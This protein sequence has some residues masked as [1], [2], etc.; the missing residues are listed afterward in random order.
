MSQNLGLDLCPHESVK[1]LYQD[2]WMKYNGSQKESGVDIYCPEDIIIPG[3]A[4]NFKIDL[5][6]KISMYHET[7]PDYSQRLGWDDMVIRLYRR[8]SIIRPHDDI[9]QTSLRF[10]NPNIMIDKQNRDYIIITVDNLLGYPIVLKRGD[11]L[12]QIHDMYD[13]R[14]RVTTYEKW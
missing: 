3:S 14:P 10:C 8:S 13:G 9:F 7:S 12:C 5:K 11:K 6:I 2:H 4:L 1:D